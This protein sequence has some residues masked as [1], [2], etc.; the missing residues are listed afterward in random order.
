[1]SGT[2][3]GWDWFGHGGGFQGYISRTCVIPA[4]DV[5]ITILTNSIDGW[6]PFWIDGAMHILRAFRTRGAPKRRIRDWIGRWWTVWGAIDLVPMGNVVVVA[7]PHL[8]NPFMDATEIEVTGRDS[9]RIALAGGY[10]SHGELVRRTRGKAGGI[11]DIWLAG[12]NAKHEKAVAT[13]IERRYAPRKRP[14]C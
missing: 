14:T 4:C 8:A 10:A 2:T 11:T 1:M 5:T 6:A 12:V 7:N 3:A 9:G 13:E